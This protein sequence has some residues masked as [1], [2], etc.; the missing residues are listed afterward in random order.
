MTP[1]E[2]LDLW[3]EFDLDEE[4]EGEVYHYQSDTQLQLALRL[5]DAHQGNAEQTIDDAVGECLMLVT[6]S[7][8]ETVGYDLHP[9]VRLNG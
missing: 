8:D 6:D 5:C 3:E 2:W 1:S 7:N 4:R 9:G